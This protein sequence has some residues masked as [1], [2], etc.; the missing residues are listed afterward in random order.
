MEV[1]P[2][3]FGGLI[4]TDIQGIYRNGVPTA[5]TAVDSP[6][7][8][9]TADTPDKVDA[10]M[11]AHAVDDF[12]AALAL[13]MKDDPSR[14][15]G[16]DPKLWQA[17]LAVM[18]ARAGD[19]TVVRAAISDAQGRPQANVSA[20]AVLLYDDFFPAVTQTVMTDS[21]GTATFSFSAMQTS[22]GSG[23]RFVHVSAGPEYPLVEQVVQL[24]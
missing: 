4:P 23:N 3:L 9:T 15:V 2:N 12:D 7:Y 22:M 5:S 14:F 18:G 24:P 8:H 20:D 19:P 10:V 6:Y 11:E 21:T 16:L 1:V 13:L 17:E